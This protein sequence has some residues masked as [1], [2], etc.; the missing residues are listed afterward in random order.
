MSKFSFLFLLASTQSL[1]F[2]Q[3][4]EQPK[5]IGSFKRMAFGFGIDAF[6]GNNIRINNPA[7]YVDWLYRS[8]SKSFMGG[9]ELESSFFTTVQINNALQTRQ[10]T[11][12]K[13]P[14]AL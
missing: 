13:V 4:Q 12:T 5:Q 2:A 11:F 1:F 9:L 14:L 6:N 10:I 3:T 8:K 7:F